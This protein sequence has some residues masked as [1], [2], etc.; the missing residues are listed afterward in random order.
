VPTYD[1]QCRKCGFIT[2]VV[3]SMLEDGPTECERCGGQLRRVFHPTGIIFRGGGFYK[4]DSRSAAAGGGAGSSSGGSSGSG[5]SSAVA[6][7]STD[8]ASGD[9]GSAPKPS[10]GGAVKGN[11]GSD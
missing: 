11:G 10:T 5:D 3:H 1:Y 2:E 7:T 8:T 4:T 9:K 6:K